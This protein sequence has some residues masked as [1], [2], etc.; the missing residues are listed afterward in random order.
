MST[1]DPVERGGDQD[2]RIAAAG[3]LR[4]LTLHFRLYTRWSEEWDHDHCAA[5]AAKFAEFD[6]PDILHEG[7]TT[8]PD[9][10]KGE[11]Y[12]WVCPACF[13]ELAEALDWKTA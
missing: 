9:Y 13:K 12:E 1:S 7:Y 8:G 10:P 6:E 4:G 11:E 2:W 5:C 3:R